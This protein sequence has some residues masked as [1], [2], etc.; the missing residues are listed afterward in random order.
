[1]GNPVMAI[2]AQIIED[3]AQQKR[4][5]VYWYRVKLERLNERQNAECDEG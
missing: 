2:K 3:E 4:P 1:M 5:R